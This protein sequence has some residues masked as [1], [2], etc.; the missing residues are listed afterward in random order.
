[1]D[2]SN[3]VDAFLKDITRPFKASPSNPV[4]GETRPE[5]P[6][7]VSKPGDATSNNPLSVDSCFMSS[8]DVGCM[9]DKQINHLTPE[10]VVALSVLAVESGVVE[11]FDKL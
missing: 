9:R 1:M 4:S 11:D 2:S 3:S 8:F 7:L 6:S 5:L 10:F